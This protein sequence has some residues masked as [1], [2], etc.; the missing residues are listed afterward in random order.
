METQIEWK[1]LN[2]HSMQS[3]NKKNERKILEK[4]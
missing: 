4:R 1:G 3:K 2:M